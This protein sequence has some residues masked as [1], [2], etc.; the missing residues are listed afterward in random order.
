MTNSS[1]ALVVM[2]AKK[3]KLDKILWDCLM[4]ANPSWPLLAIWSDVQTAEN[5]LELDYPPTSWPEKFWV[6]QIVLELFITQKHW[7]DCQMFQIV[8]ELFITQKHWSDCQMFQIV[9]DLFITRKRCSSWQM[10]HLDQLVCLV[11]A[12]WEMHKPK[13]KQTIAV[14]GRVTI[15]GETLL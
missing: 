9:L 6:L 11:A 12:P 3:S 5:S 4:F 1:P 2:G 8:L 14:L 15:S 13:G 7:S 10:F